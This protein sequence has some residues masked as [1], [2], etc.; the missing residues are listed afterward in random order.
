MPEE[1]CGILLGRVGGRRWIV[2]EV[3]PA[4]N[5]WA[6]DR[7]KRYEID[8]QG[9]FDAFRSAADGGVKVLGFYHS[10]PGGGLA[11][12]AVDADL[13]WPGKAYLIVGMPRSPQDDV[14][15]VRCWLR[16]AENDES[17]AAMVEMAVGG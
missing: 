17:T 2:E 1:C 6:G 12:S 11:P 5:V 7:R 4:A 3:R 8:P 16:A 10:H 9:L 15:D 14:P 13:A